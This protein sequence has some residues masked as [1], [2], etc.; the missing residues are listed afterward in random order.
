[1][2]MREKSGQG[3]VPGFSMHQTDQIQLVDDRQ[4]PPPHVSA[5]LQPTSR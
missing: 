3:P 5:Y 4:S 2:F 1:M